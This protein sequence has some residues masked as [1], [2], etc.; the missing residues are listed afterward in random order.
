[1]YLE[2]LN[3]VNFMGATFAEILSPLTLIVGPNRK[4]KTRIQRAAQM[5]CGGFVP[6]CG[7]TNP[8]IYDNLGNGQPLSV[9]GEFSTGEAMH[10]A[11][12]KE[13]K[14][15]TNQKSG[16]GLDNDWTVPAVLIT[17]TEYLDLSGKDRINFLFSAM[18]LTNAEFSVEKLLA[19][20]KNIKLEPQTEE[21]EQVIREITDEIISGDQLR[22][23]AETPL[24]TWLDELSDTLDKKLTEANAAVKRMDGT[25]KGLIEL[26]SQESAMPVSGSVE[27][28]LA[29]ARKALA[30]AEA[31]VTRIKD[32]SADLAK[33]RAR[34]TQI[35]TELAK[36]HKNGKAEKQKEID[37]HNVTIAAYSNEQHRAASEVWN[38]ASTAVA[39]F[40]TEKRLLEKQQAD[41]TAEHT[42]VLTCT[43]CP[44]CEAENQDWR[45]RV[46]KKHN[47]LMS[48][49]IKKQK[50][51]EKK[52]ET[53]LKAKEDAKKLMDAHATAQHAANQA[54][55]KVPG[56]MK[57]ITTIEKEETGLMNLR[58]EL[59]GLQNIP[60]EETNAAAVTTRDAAQT[61]VDTLEEK[62][63]QLIQQRA[64]VSSQAKAVELGKLNLAEQAVTKQA[65]K[66]LM[67]AKDKLTQ[68]TIAPLL[69][70]ANAICQPLLDQPLEYR[71]KQI[72]WTLP[73]TK[74]FQSHTTFSGAEQA[75]VFA[76]LSVALAVRSPIRVVM[77]DEM[78][79][80]DRE[81]KLKLALLMRQL[82]TEK[83]IDQFI[84][85]DTED[86]DYCRTF[87]E[88]QYADFTFIRL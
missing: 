56:L 54:N 70:S 51:L 85:N 45:E 11:W 37:A 9:T 10:R 78:G 55:L 66:I 6:C 16:R 29:Q 19:D 31:E 12:H 25:V 26:G 4:G 39:G 72:G 71:D 2:K 59:E 1:M 81:R 86:T 15:V 35:E 13:G 79:V 27:G 61:A 33:K 36:P 40:D 47:R 41:L 38:K 65:I 53:A 48:D 88:A 8:A 80:I 34:K 28:E 7:S 20:I 73:G 84:G 14:T 21:A 57:E 69:A 62:N 49:I 82:V 77:I 22:V 23:H 64:N 67:E 68:Q 60:T 30:T 44:T 75:I 32:A 83:K 46:E 52:L 58:T 3:V 43:H 74:R 76:A 50:A 17:A 87:T 24:Q 18:D 42:K 63:R 5:V